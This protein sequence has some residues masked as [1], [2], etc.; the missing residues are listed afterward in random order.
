MRKCNFTI[1]RSNFIEIT[2]RQGCSPVNL[3]QIF[4]T[5][6]LKVTLEGCFCTLQINSDQTTVLPT[7][8][9]KRYL[10]KKLLSLVE[11]YVS[12]QKQSIKIVF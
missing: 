11:E 12:F 6:F 10:G 9:I 8:D 7:T 5:L 1:L 3:L 2:L 4:R